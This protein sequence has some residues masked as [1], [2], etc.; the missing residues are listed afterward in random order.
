[1]KIDVTNTVKFTK[2]D[3][4]KMLIELV[5]KPGAKVVF[6]TAEVSYDPREQYSSREFSYATVEFKEVRQLADTSTRTQ[7]WQADTS[8]N[9]WDR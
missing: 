1:M 5:G 3:L 4:T 2:D 9:Q 8:Y 6:H 7:S